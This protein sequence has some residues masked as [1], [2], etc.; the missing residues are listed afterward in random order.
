MT[1]AG[2]CNIG[3]T[4]YMNTALQCLGN[5]QPFIAII[6]AMKAEPAKPLC[7]EL[8]KFYETPTTPR[9]PTDLVRVLQPKMKSI[10]IREQNDVAEFVS[11]FI[12]AL[13]KE[14]GADM[15]VAIETLIQSISYKNTKYDRQR[16]RMDVSWME[17][18]GKEY[19]PLIDT[20]Y[21]QHI[22][23]IDCAHCHKLWHNYEVFQAIILPLPSTHTHTHTQP[24]TMSHLLDAYFKDRRLTEWKCDTCGRGA[25]S[26]QSIA[27]WRNPTILTITLQR[28]DMTQSIHKNDIP[29]EVP[30]DLD[31]SRFSLGN[32]YK[33]YVLKSVA[34]HSG[35]Y[36]GGHYHCVC[37]RAGES[38]FILYDDEMT[39]TM[40]K[41]PDLSRGYVFFYEAVG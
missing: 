10:Y 31:L 5:L 38:S 17:Q 3:N 34:V 32:T 33:K 19:S 11:L 6:S 28:F 2:I 41:M 29:V 37:R 20:L 9:N 26:V 36:F 30:L 23:Q 7:Y 21:G 25:Q 27:L 15:R 24:L 18:V 40:E 39:L 12:D 14:L 22:S 8:A 4:C 35:S 16:Q 1:S 13:N